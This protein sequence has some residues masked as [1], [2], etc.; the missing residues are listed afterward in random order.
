MTNSILVL[1]NISKVISPSFA[2][3]D[4][5]WEVFENEVHIL[6]GE[7][8]SGK[9]SLMNIVSGIFKKDT[10]QIFISGTEVDIGSYF[11]AKKY[12]ITIVPQDGSLFNHFT[13]TENIFV[14]NKKYYLKGIKFINKKLTHAECNALLEKLNI[15]L[16]GK[17]LVRN[18][19]LAEKKLVE[20][21]RAYAARPKILIIDEPTASFSEIECKIFYNIIRS[22][23]KAGVTVILIT[24]RFDDIKNIGDRVSIIRE[25]SLVCTMDSE[26]IHSSF[27]V[28]SMSGLDFSERYP[29]LKVKI[30][31]EIFRVN[32]INSDDILTDVSFTLRRREILGVAGLLGSGKTR[33]ARCLIGLDKI[34]FGDIYLRSGKVSISKPADALALNI[35]YITEDRIGE[36]VFGNLSVLNNMLSSNL[37]KVS[38]HGFIDAEKEYNYGMH[39]KKELKIKADS[40]YNNMKTLSGGSQQKVLISKLIMSNIEIAIMD[41]I[42]M[43]LDI[44]SKIDMY[45]IMNDMVRNNVSIILI[46]SDINELRGMCDRIIVL[47]NGK[48]ICSLTREEA[49]YEKIIS[50]ATGS[51]TD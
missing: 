23:K 34:Q 50:Y 46:S 30:G 36:G 51:I 41:E 49:T 4:V 37:K 31:E 35:G 33:L 32:H 26:E 7:N 19:S 44:A 8:A 5:N 10:G 17:M 27:F 1:K 47:Y 15:P 3:H 48:S 40:L 6:I 43:G 9:S 20:I 29:K 11:D 12:G 24:H 13:V 2:I 22:L 45:N 14:D 39:Y 38:N 16:N 28:K 25:G 21:A 42:T 18:L